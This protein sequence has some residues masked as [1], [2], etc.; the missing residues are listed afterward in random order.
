MMMLLLSLTTLIGIA[1]KSTSKQK[2]KR[3]NMSAIAGVTVVSAKLSTTKPAKTKEVLEG[4]ETEEV[5]A[6][7][8]ESPNPPEP[9]PAYKEE[10]LYLLSHVIAGEANNCDQTMKLYVGSVVLN[11]LASPKFPSTLREVIFQKGQYQCVFSGHFK[12]Q[13]NED[14]IQITKQL[15]TNGSILP[16]NVLFQAEFRQGSGI[17]RKYQNEYFCY[18]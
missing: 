16:P 12:E 17:Y 7:E 4:Q 11:R 8:P 18:E 15:L 13:P 9:E 5:A 14:T 10:D 2:S 3:P 1:S 6:P